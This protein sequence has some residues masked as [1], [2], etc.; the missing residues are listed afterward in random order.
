LAIS[1]AFG[2]RASTAN[3]QQH[4]RRALNY[5]VVPTLGQREVLTEMKDGS[6]NNTGSIGMRLPQKSGKTDQYENR[7]R[8]HARL[9]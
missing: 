6:F 1:S 7:I 8:Q 3:A 5:V 2:W 4:Q 9:N